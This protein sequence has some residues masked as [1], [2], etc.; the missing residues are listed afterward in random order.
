MTKIK[1]VILTAFIVAVATPAVLSLF[2]G[3]ASASGYMVSSGFN[4]DVHCT[5]GG[6]EDCPP[7]GILVDG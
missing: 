3:D 5:D 2:S 1:R 7:G 4:G 6:S